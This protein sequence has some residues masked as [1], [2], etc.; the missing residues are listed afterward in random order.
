MSEVAVVAAITGG[1]SV[2]TSAVTAMVTWAVSQ[3]SATVELAKVAEETKRMNL[4]NREEER[5]NRQSTY[6]EFIRVLIHFYQALGHEVTR[7][8]ADTLCDEYNDL[9]AGVMLFGPPSVRDGADEINEVYN[10]LC[11]AVAQQEIASPN[12]SFEQHWQQATAPF[13][14]PFSERY[15]DLIALMHADVT[16]GII[17]DS[18]R[19]TA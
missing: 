5:R 3:N 14:L 9:L 12:E 16:D 4:G 1:A 7:K 6:H 17:E 11:N 18:P 13:A 8:E 10:E 2:L 19:L 15:W